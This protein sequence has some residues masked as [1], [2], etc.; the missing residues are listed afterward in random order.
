MSSIKIAT[1]FESSKQQK[2]V[3]DLQQESILI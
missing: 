2:T 3:G 1:K